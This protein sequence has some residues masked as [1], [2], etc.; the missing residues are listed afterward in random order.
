[1]L[2]GIDTLHIG[3]IF[4]LDDPLALLKKALKPTDESAFWG[5]TRQ[6]HDWNVNSKHVSKC[7]RKQ[8][9]PTAWL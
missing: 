4:V 2:V 9:S 8:D 3:N 5:I 1:M 7:F 6:S